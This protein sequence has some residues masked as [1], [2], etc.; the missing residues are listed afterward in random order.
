MSHKSYPSSDRLSTFITGH[1]LDV[2]N[3]EGLLAGAID[4]AR[5]SFENDTDHRP[6]LAA[7]SATERAFD[8][9]TNGPL[10]FCG[11]L[12]VAPTSVTYQPYGSSAETLTLRQDYTL[13]PSNALSMGEPITR[14]RFRRRWTTPLAPEQL[15]S[16]LITGR[17]GY[18][19]EVPDD[20]YQAILE[21]GAANVW[22]QLTQSATGGL[23]GWK[24]GERSVD[25]GDNRWTA[26]NEKWTGKGCNYDKAVSIYRRMGF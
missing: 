7:T 5:R 17:W 23:L 6:F 1:G 24:H 2:T 14:L 3:Y 10:L 19:T 11:S 9:P 16:V 22:T 25:Y 13:E 21:R 15:Q 4:A 12:A 18:A 20:A 8:P 26:L